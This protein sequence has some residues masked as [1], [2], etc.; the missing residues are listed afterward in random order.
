MNLGLPLLVCLSLGALDDSERQTLFDRVKQPVRPLLVVDGQSG[1]VTF[2]H[3]KCVSLGIK[4]Y[5]PDL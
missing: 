5:E 4:I 2:T 1:D 3:K